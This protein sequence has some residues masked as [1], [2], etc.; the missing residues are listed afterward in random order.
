[1]FI[2]VH[3]SYFARNFGDTLLVKE[4]CDQIAARVGAD[5]VVLAHEGK[6][7]EQREIGYPVCKKS[8]RK[9]V[10]HLV[11]AG[12]GY[13]GEPAKNIEQWS[14]GCR[15][16]H[17]S[18]I[19]DYLNAKKLVLGVGFGEVSNKSLRNDIIKLFE[20]SE[21]VVVRDKESYK[22]LCD[23][24]CKMDNVSVA[25]DIALLPLL[26]NFYKFHESMNIKK[27][28]VHL[29][30]SDDITK[31]KVIKTLLQKFDDSTYRYT[32]LRDSHGPFIF[33]NMT[34]RK[35][36]ALFKNRESITL[37]R[38]SDVESFTHAIS[39]QD[40]IVTDKLHV[41]IVGI[42]NGVRVIGVGKHP[43]IK[44]L[45]SQL[46]ASKFYI[47]DVSDNIESFI[48]ALESLSDYNLSIEEVEAGSEL[49]SCA[50]DYFFGSPK[51]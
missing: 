28:G 15:E 8:D 20:E 10:T 40:L 4:V 27:I 43:K 44:R 5:K 37:I 49:I 45:Y 24:G 7:Q 14:E 48:D 47:K 21:K 26:N 2:A 31:S 46:N 29:Q 22:Y 13:F 19:P 38:I 33:K 6:K 16:K 12:G 34:F 35:E 9:R 32:L 51:H 50:L 41:G 39:S 17:L 36:L 42:A 23:Y 3:G 25:S 11:F 1:M 18:W 30:N